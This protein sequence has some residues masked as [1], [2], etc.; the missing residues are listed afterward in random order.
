MEALVAKVV[1]HFVQIPSA[2]AAARADLSRAAQTRP[3]TATTAEHFPPAL[4]IL[5]A[6]VSEKKKKCFIQGLE[7]LL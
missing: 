6:T 1:V 5:P 3:G 2:A 7:E 4:H